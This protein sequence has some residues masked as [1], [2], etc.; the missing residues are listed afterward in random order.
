MNG[1][2]KLYQLLK[3]LNIPFEY[4]EHPEAPTFL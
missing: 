1:S 3:H 4:L 2:E